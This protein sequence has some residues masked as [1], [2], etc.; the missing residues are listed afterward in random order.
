M[1][2]T[3]E[4]FCR[5]ASSTC[6][7]TSSLKEPTRLS[8]KFWGGRRLASRRCK[9]SYRFVCCGRERA[10]CSLG[11]PIGVE[12]SPLRGSHY[13]WAALLNKVAGSSSTPRGDRWARRSP[14]PIQGR[15]DSAG[16]RFMEMGAGR[17]VRPSQTPPWT[18]LRALWT[19]SGAIVMCGFG[20]GFVSNSHRSKPVLARRCVRASAVENACCRSAAAAAPAP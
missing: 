13:C 10:W 4:S 11:L 2:L 19:P 16:R 9:A 8:S 3:R 17:R 18:R 7:R 20:F 6:Q 1:A 14:R 15:A 12:G 5:Y